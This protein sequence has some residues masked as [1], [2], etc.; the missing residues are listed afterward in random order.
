[1]ASKKSPLSTGAPGGGAKLLP[2]ELDMLA[3]ATGQTRQQLQGGWFSPGEPMAPQAPDTVRGRQF[4]FPFAVNTSPRPR[5]EQGERNIDFPTLRRMA[6]PAQGGLDLIRLAVETCKDKMAGQKWQIMGRDGKDGGDKAKRVMD[7][8]AEPDG[9]NDFLSWQR[10]IFEDHYVIDQPAIYLRPTTKGIFLPEIVDGGTLKRI[11]SDRGRVPLPPL[12][13]YGQA[14]KG[15]AAVEYTVDEMIVRAYNLRPN[16]IYGMSPVEQVINIVN[17]SLRRLLHQTEFY[18]DGTI[19]DALL[20]APP[21]MNPDQVLDFQTSWDVVMTGQTAT[22]RHGR[23]VPSGTK[24]QATKEPSLNDP[25][26]EWLARIICWCFSVS[27]QALVKAQNRATAQT[28][29]ETA[30]EEGVEPRKLWFKSLM[31]SILRRC[32]GVGDLQFSWQDEEI[33]DPLVKAQV[34]QIALGGGGSKPWMTPDEV[35]DMGYGMDPM[36]DEQKDELAPPPPPTP[37]LSPGANTPDG[38]PGAVD[39]SASQPP[40]AK[41]PGKQPP[42]A[43]A[44]AVQKKKRSGTLTPIDRERPAVVKARKA[45]S[46]IMQKAFAAQKKKALA[47]AADALG[48]VAKADGDDPFA[49]ITSA[50]A[51]KK[52]LAD[53]QKQLEDLAQDGAG[54]GLNQVGGMIPP[55]DGGT[56]GGTGAEAD[57]LD[58]MLNQANEKAVAW[59]A[60]HAAQLVT[61]INDT[62]RKGL[63]DLTQKAL[64]D[65]LTNDQL[66]DN[67]SGFTGFDDARADMIATTETAFADVQGNL[68]GWRESGVVEGKRWI[69]GSGCCEE[70]EGL[71]GATVGLDEDFP[72]DG[73][74]GPPHH[75]N[76]RCDIVPE[77]MSQADIDAAT[78]GDE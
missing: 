74:D 62:T 14:L 61:E 12:P 28:A 77:V 23:W 64:A 21:G 48:K 16:R 18:T 15:M 55:G 29:K 53:I 49:G 13:A 71:D 35:R 37:I 46:G 10:L 11:V 2:I 57:A 50:A 56:G 30:Q 58:A 20:E 4:D 31:D 75:P 40:P 41:K 67:I 3:A 6:D 44:G 68:A 76:C 17:L 60:D 54:E 51:L 8:L 36:T 38:K 69:T 7:L 22:R 32:Y 33:T 63:N 45:I 73:G 42:A 27:P 19:P 9:V 34:Y 70:C 78:E 72:D 59:A 66:A 52:L 47:I 1:M 43:K 24:Y 26:D 39:E 5:G 65:G 25:I